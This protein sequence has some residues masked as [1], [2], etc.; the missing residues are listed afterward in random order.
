MTLRVWADYNELTVD[1]KTHTLT[2]WLEGL[3]DGQKV[4][5]NDDV[6]TY[7][8]S[9]N[10]CPGKVVHVERDHIITILLDQAAFA[11]PSKGQDYV[12]G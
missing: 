9:G 4:K 3:E 10:T 1:G 8:H 7:D 12:G 2:D 5:I 6:E 11:G